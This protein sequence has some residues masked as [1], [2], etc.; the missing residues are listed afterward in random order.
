MCSQ[1]EGLSNSLLEYMAAGRA[2][3]ATAVGG[4][5]ELIRDGENGLLV[6]PEVPQQLAAAILRLLSDRPLAVALARAARTEVAE[7]FAWPAVVRQVENFYADVVCARSG[8]VRR[9]TS[10]NPVRVT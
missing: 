5:V 1:S 3:V 10:S 8:T 9:S 2:I 4:N 7:R 6:P